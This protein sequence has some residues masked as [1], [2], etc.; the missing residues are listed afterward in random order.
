MPV[1]LLGNPNIH[2]ILR[3]PIP[4]DASDVE[5]CDPRLESTVAGCAGARL[6]NTYGEMS[7]LFC[8]RQRTRTELRILGS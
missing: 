6:R 4:E 3:Q 7:P 5:Q 1:L 2:A 8:D